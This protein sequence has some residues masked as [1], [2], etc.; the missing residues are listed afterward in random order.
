M[1][2]VLWHVNFGCWVFTKLLHQPLLIGQGK[3][4]GKAHR[5]ISDQD[6][7]RQII[8]HGQNR[9]S[10]GEITLGYRELNRIEEW[11]IWNNCKPPSQQHLAPHPHHPRLNF[12]P[13]SFISS[14]PSRAGW[15][16][17][18]GLSVPCVSSLLLFTPHAL[19]WSRVGC[20]HRIQPLQTAPGSILP[21]GCS[22]SKIAPAWFLSIESGPSGTKRSSV[23]SLWGTD[24]RTKTFLKNPFWIYS[25]MM[26]SPTAFCKDGI[27]N[28]FHSWSESR[29]WLF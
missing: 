14:L 13:I 24:F 1:Y 20:S 28:K 21:M 27:S 17:M 4:W 12:L 15:W 3:L 29:R 19:P 22:S 9:H 2:S 11:E 8:Y 10:L 6:K 23:G 7:D 18:G 25:G 5:L 16:A 26:D